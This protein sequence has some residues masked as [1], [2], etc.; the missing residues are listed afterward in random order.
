[1]T[2]PAFLAPDQPIRAEITHRSERPGP[3]IVAFWRFGPYHLARLAAARRLLPARGLAFGTDDGYGWDHEASEFVDTLLPGQSI[4]RPDPET[5]ARRFGDVLARD[6]PRAVA[7]PGWGDPVSLAVLREAKARRIPLVLMSESTAWDEPR[8][9]WKEAVKRR[10]VRLFDAALVGGRPQADYVAQLGMPRERIFP[11]YD[12]VDNTHFARP[13]AP[14]A[15]IGPWNGRPFFLASARFIAKKNQPRLLRAFARYR[16]L[17]GADARN[18]V[19]L[20]DGP[21]RAELEALRAQ[22]ELGP[23]LL[24]PGFR[25]YPELPGWYQAA[26]CFVHASTSEQWGLVV[27]EAMAAGLP[28]LV[29]NRCGCAVDLVQ[30][31]VNGFTFDPL[32]VEELAR[33]MH[34]VAHGAVDRAAMGAASRRIIADWGPE[35]FA[36]GL[37][38]AVDCALAQPRR[39]LSALDRALLWALI[40][41]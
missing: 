21:L 6:R 14:P 4:E 31:G 30:D 40:R 19:L 25:Q 33:L 23:H 7:I 28:V 2:F 35:R 9:A 26:S 1:M 16:A 20:G 18:L 8:V 41:R 39:P 36:A 29:S 38:A 17:V 27:N 11:G 32:D 37:E 34:R 12:V 13:A 22:L 10:I 3:A 5:S 15:E 24:M